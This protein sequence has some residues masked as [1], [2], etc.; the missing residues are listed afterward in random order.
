[1]TLVTGP[2]TLPDPEGITTV[3]VETAQHMLEAVRRGLPADIAVF[4]AAVA[5]WR[6]ATK[7]RQKIKKTGDRPVIDLVENPDILATVADLEAERPQHVIGFAAE[8]RDVIAF[9]KKKLVAKGADWIVANDVSSTT[10]VL[11]GDNNTVHIVTPESVE[12]WPQMSKD[13]VAERLML[14][15]AEHLRRTTAAAE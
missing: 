11:G 3:H 12:S 15:A 2:V 10:R 8:T 14:R 4:A 9:A 6:S 13:E 5:D 1:M 7:P